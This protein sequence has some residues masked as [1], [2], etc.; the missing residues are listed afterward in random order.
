MLEY[1]AF[2]VFA[3]DL[4]NFDKRGD[5]VVELVAAVIIV[6]LHENE[7]D[8]RV[9]KKAI[10]FHKRTMVQTTCSIYSHHLSLL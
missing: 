6:L 4:E 9:P 5:A 1:N 8:R 2:K 10:D 7:A 3:A